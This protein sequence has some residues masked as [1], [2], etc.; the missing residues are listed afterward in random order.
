MVKFP[1]RQYTRKSAL[2]EEQFKEMEKTTSIKLPTDT[3][4][5]IL[6]ALSQASVLPEAKQVLTYLAEHTTYASKIVFGF[7]PY[8][9]C[10]AIDCTSTR[11]F[12]V[13]S[14]YVVITNDNCNGDHNLAAGYITTEVYVTADRRRPVD[15]FLDLLKSTNKQYKSIFV[16][17]S[18][19]SY[20]GYTDIA[21]QVFKLISDKK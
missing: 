17:L 2:N 11:E 15:K 18:L 16:W 12:A 8:F 19:E 20:T 21:N 5:S 13:R 1:Y 7:D 14:S 4:V 10:N 6:R 3:T 9:V